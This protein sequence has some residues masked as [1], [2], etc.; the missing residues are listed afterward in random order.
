MRRSSNNGTLYSGSISLHY[1]HLPLLNVGLPENRLFTFSIRGN[2]KIFL[3]SKKESGLPDSRAERGRIAA[4]YIFAR[5]R[6]LA[7]RF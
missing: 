3:S 6:I 2:T 7:E 5:V 4:Y 1:P